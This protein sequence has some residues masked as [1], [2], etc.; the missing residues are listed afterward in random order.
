[1]VMYVCS[2]LWYFFTSSYD[3]VSSSYLRSSLLVKHS[4]AG[5]FVNCSSLDEG[6][7]CY[8]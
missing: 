8:N 6:V 5:I 3:Q 4:Y 2:Y 7:L 1:M